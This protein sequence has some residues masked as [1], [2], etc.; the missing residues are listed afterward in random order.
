M[1]EFI[2][3]SKSYAAGKN[4]FAVSGVSLQ[5]KDTET[6]GLI[7]VN[8]AGKT[9]IIKAAAGLH[10]ASSGSVLIDSNDAETVSADVL[11]RSVGY[12]PEQSRFPK[13][14]TAA[15]YLDCAAACR[16]LSGAQKEAA[17]RQAV[18]D[19]FLYGHLSK[20]IAALS[21]GCCRRLSLASAIV[22]A[23]QNI[24]LDEPFEGLDPEQTIHLRRLIKKLSEKRA[25]LLSTHIMSEAQALCSKIYVV[26]GGKIAASGTAESIASSYGAA[27]LEE[28]FLKIAAEAAA[29]RSAQ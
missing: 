10:F 3:F 25:V 12:V 29:N 1:I 24:V 7:G 6:T 15:E 20:K 9:T 8:G 27:N 14:L 2:D 28:A 23:P 13:N 5:A 22:H 19:C 16:G 18:N 11:R 26:S 17:I 21:K 4:R